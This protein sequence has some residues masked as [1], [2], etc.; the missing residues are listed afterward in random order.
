M[1]YWEFADY[2]GI[3]AGAHGKITRCDA[4]FVLRRAKPKQPRRYMEAAARGTR[5]GNEYVLGP[6]D[7]LV[8]F[9]L[10]ALRLRSGFK[11][12]LF[13]ARTGLPAET[14]TPALAQ[15]TERGLVNISERHVAPTPLGRRFLNE[16]ILHFMH[17][18]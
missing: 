14:I 1:N 12:S 16:L 17:D 7:A 2:L 18:P 9:M 13:E 15:A 11:L 10:N 3:G 8:E 4:A 5:L 6:E